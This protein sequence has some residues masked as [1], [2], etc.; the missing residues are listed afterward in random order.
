MNDDEYDKF[1]DAILD[2]VDVGEIKQISKVPV[3]FRNY[4]AKNAERIAGWNNKPYWVKDNPQFINEIPEVEKANVLTYDESILTSNSMFSKHKV[5][6]DNEFD[7]VH[8]ELNS[9]EKTAIYNYSAS[10]FEKLN[11]YLLGNSSPLPIEKEY[12]DNMSNALETALAKMDSNFEGVVY[13]GANLPKTRLDDIKNI[14]ENGGV[15]SEPFFQSSS[16]GAGAE[17]PGSVR[18]IINSKTGKKIQS[19]TKYGVEEK[20]VLFNR[21]AKFKITDI[22]EGE[23]ITTIYMDEI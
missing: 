18:Y 11:Q 8:N 23:K 1:E 4:V 3:G 5:K 20:E 2:G 13:R 9:I 22:Q 14:F 10:G 12:L 16:Y 6:I 17:F 15:Y 19:L 7:D 21:N